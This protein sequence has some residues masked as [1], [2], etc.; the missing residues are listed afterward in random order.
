MDRYTA[1]SDVKGVYLA[2]DDIA[3]VVTADTISR[4][5]VKVTQKFLGIF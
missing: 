5:K 1:K 3:Y 2:S 4:V